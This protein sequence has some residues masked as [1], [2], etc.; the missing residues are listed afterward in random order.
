[1]KIHVGGRVKF[2]KCILLQVANASPYH[3]VCNHVLRY[4][5]YPYPR[6]YHQSPYEH[7]PAY[8]VPLSLLVHIFFPI[9]CSCS[10]LAGLSGRPVHSLCLEL[11]A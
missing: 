11:L 3:P 8:F 2:F 7:H 5:H 9:T 10:L 6:L 1:M 4:D